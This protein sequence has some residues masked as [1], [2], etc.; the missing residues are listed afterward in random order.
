MLRGAVRLIRIPVTATYAALVGVVAI[1][2][3]T[4]APQTQD[5]IVRHASTNLH[6]LDH[7]RVGTLLISAF[8][9]DAGP[10]IAWLPGLIA[11]LALIELLWGSSRLV[12]AFL[13]G[14]V[15]ATL[16]VAAGLAVAVTLTWLPHSVSRAIDVG[17]SYGA[18]GVLGALT[19]TIPRRW[20]SAWVGWWVVLSVVVVAVDRDFTGVGHAV[21]LLLGMAVA[22]RFGTPR[23]WNGL[24][25]GLCCVAVAFGTLIIANSA[26]AMMVALPASALVALVS[27]NVT[28]DG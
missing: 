26:P 15:G 25:A 13:V 14:H 21:A 4:L 7:G 11:L 12:I 1:G 9:V 16:L 17:M 5:R 3:G 20:R 22:R 8:V 6:N 2:F 23:P 27:S 19:P 18:I 10:L 28:G 24:C